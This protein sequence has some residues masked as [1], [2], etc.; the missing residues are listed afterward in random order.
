MDEICDN[1]HSEPKDDK[2]KEAQRVPLADLISLETVVNVLVRKGICTSEELFEEE[3]KQKM[4]KDQVKNVSIAHTK[5]SEHQENGRPH[6][7]QSSWL[8]RKMSKRRWS[9]TLGTAL[10]GWKCKKVKINRK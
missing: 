2:P 7:H 6:K 10:F 5:K 3:K 9:R 4:Y 8:K 1:Q